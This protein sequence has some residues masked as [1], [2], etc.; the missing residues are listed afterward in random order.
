M[1]LTILNLYV[2]TLAFE[3]LNELLDVLLFTF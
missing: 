1:A 3:N 2:S